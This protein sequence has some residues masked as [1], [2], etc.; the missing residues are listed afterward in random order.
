MKKLSCY[1]L[2][3][4]LL[5]LLSACG[6]EQQRIKASGKII[7]IGVIGP[8]SGSEQPL[9]T[10]SLEGIR[11]ALHMHPYLNNGDAIELIIEDDRNEPELTIKAFKKLVEMDKVAAVILS[12][13][14]GSALAVNEIADNYQTPVLAL[15]A[16]HP[17]ISR[18]TKFVS[19]ICF[20]NVFQGKVAAL[21]VRDELLIDRV[22]VFS[23]EDSIYS[24]SL[25]E[26]FIRMFR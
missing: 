11:T 4:L 14:S 19:Q 8:M 15:L 17:Q 10:D 22:A 2:I 9:G 13:T 5:V 24:S 20:D 12:S 1:I 18:D 26:E 6:E 3:T 25:D 21:F 7:K 16:T 23:N